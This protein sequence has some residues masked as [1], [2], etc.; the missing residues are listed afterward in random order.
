MLTPAILIVNNLPIFYQGFG[1]REATMLFAFGNSQSAMT[2]DLILTIS[3]VS[4]V[5]MIVSALIGSIF[6][7]FLLF[8]RNN[9]SST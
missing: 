5:V 8:R 9:L 4:G 1:G 3:L 2:P 6:V 7:P